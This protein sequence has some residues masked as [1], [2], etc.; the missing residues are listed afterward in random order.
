MANAGSVYTAPVAETAVFGLLLLAKRLR[1]DPE[2]RRPKL[3]RRYAEITELAGKRALILGA[4][5]I[6]TAIADRL[7]GF[8]MRVDA[9]DP[10][11][12]ESDRFEALFRDRA[13]LE[14]AIGD[15]DAVISALPDNDTTRGFVDEALISLM[16]PGAFVVSVGRLAA[17][18]RGALYRALKEKRLGAAALD[19]FEKA[20]NPITNKFRRLHN[21][22][23]FPGVAA[24]SR[25]VGARLTAHLT[26]NVCAA[27][28]G[29]E[30]SNV[31]NGVKK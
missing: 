6:G 3:T 21:T 9:Y 16:K 15:Y 5:S 18:D 29:G 23:V 20:P 2:R 27:L 12:A 25:E 24:L 19:I 26:R 22:V 28:S 8:E 17:F 30:I 13:A 11:C 14:A 4:G 10:Y 1:C 7:A 31:I